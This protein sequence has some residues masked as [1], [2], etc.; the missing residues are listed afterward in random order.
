MNERTPCTFGLRRSTVQRIRAEAD[1]LG[2]TP[3]YLVEAIIR[4][5]L[6]EARRA[7]KAAAAILAGAAREIEEGAR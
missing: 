4:A 3:T 7:R 1:R 5:Y 2:T 6:E